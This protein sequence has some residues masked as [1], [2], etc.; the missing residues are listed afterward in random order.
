MTLN[1]L[2]DKRKSAGLSQ[3]ELASKIGIGR[4]T[5]S[6]IETGKRKPSYEVMTK[7]SKALNEPVIIQ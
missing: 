4:S 3:N 5:L 7:I 1:E 6:L 2:K